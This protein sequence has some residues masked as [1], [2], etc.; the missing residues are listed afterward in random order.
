[1]KRNLLYLLFAGCLTA[2]L[3]SCEYQLNSENYRDITRPD[4]TKM[5]QMDLSPF[6]TQYLFTVPTSVSYNLNTFGLTVY[7]VAF[8]VGDQ[9]IHSG[10]EAVG[11]FV[12]EPGKW[13]VGTQTMTM[14]VTTNTNTGSLADLLQAEGLVFQQSWDVYLDGQKPD[15]VEITQIANKDGILKIEWEKYKRFNFEKYVLYRNSG[16]VEGPY[17]AHAIAEFTDPAQTTW[18]DSS[19]IGDTG[20]YW[21]EVYGSNQKTA[22]QKRR[23]DSP[24]PELKLLW[25]KGDSASFRWT[26]NAYYKAVDHVSLTVPDFYPEPV[27]NL[28][29]SDDINDTTCVIKGLRFGNSS[30]YT[31]SVYP[32]TN[33]PIYQ[34][35]QVLRSSVSF[36]IGQ[37][38]VPFYEFAGDPVNN[39]FYVS[40]NNKIYRYGYPGMK[41]Q[42]SCNSGIFPTWFVSLYDQKLVTINNSSMKMYAKDNL[43]NPVSYSS[44][45]FGF[46]GFWVD[47]SISTNNRMV[48]PVGFSA[49]LYAGNIE[50]LMFTSDNQEL[51]WCTLSPDG[52]YIFTRNYLGYADQ[53]EV[54]IWRVTQTGF[55]AVGSLPT[56]NYS[57]L[58][59]VPDGGHR[60]AALKGYQSNTNGVSENH[61]AVYDTETVQ[62]V[63]EFP[64]RVGYLGGMSPADKLLLL[65]SHVPRTDYTEYAYLYNY[66]T[67]ELVR[68]ISLHPQISNLWLYRSHLFSSEGYSID[69]SEF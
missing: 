9:S 37:Q 45:D 7:N 39:Q 35:N 22:G 38:L 14:V 57:Y 24:V 52:K 16:D 50:Q 61:F 64:V 13:G 27:I 54:K 63:A 43:Q 48:G 47:C 17:Y 12:L 26:K 30:T 29:S 10:N 1:M 67:G 2:S 31:L 66:E 56:A 19:F 5:I 11:G 41:L 44:Y 3:W 25:V 58:G 28:F 69:I 68:R 34:D 53:T 46:Y 40:D 21:V 23:T 6:E 8:F 32:K 49:G 65:Y 55:E 62:A 4:T 18:A 60:L 33:N 15:P 36:G 59:W 42:E 51:E 20:I